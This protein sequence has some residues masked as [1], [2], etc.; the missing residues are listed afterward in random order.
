MGFLR[1][2]KIR[3]FKESLP[4]DVR[5]LLKEV[6]TSDVRLGASNQ[7]ITRLLKGVRGS[8]FP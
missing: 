2:K 7:T 8:A 5:L 4:E 1:G 3:I 6:K